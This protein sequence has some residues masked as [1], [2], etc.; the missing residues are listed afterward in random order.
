MRGRKG[1]WASAGERSSLRG[2]LASLAITAIVAALLLPAMLS[3]RDR[4][5]E[6]LALVRAG[7]GTISYQGAYSAKCRP[8]PRLARK[9]GRHVGPGTR[10]E[11]VARERGWA[12]TDRFGEPC[13]IP[14]WTLVATPFDR[15]AAYRLGSDYYAKEPPGWYEAERQAACAANWLNRATCFINESVRGS[16]G[17]P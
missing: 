10:L 6:W 15:M 1:R 16:P 4:R 7:G 17:L 9:G 11:V 5:D 2:G 13:W 14:E 3:H 8:M 12:L